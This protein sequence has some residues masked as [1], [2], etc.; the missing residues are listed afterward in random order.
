M[1]QEERLDL[2]VEGRL[3]G[4]VEAEED[5]GVFCE[6]RSASQPATR[7]YHS[8]RGARRGDEGVEEY[9]MPSLLVAY[10]Y[11]PLARWYIIPAVALPAQSPPE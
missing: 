8:Q 6:G 7:G 9:D 1:G 2:L 11:K 4:I 10:R 5:D 3:A